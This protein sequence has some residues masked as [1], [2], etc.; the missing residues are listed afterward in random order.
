M[1]ICPY[2]TVN[3]GS[4][5]FAALTRLATR[6]PRRVLV[7]ALAIIVTAAAFGTGAADRLDPYAA[8]PGNR[9]RSRRRAA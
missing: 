2:T 9:I 3:Q 6:R 4:I 7:L 8:G 5:V 1:L